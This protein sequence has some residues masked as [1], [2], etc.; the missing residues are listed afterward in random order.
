MVKALG[1]VFGSAAGQLIFPARRRVARALA[2]RR[3]TSAAVG[4]PAP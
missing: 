3:K 2:A 1:G 4:A